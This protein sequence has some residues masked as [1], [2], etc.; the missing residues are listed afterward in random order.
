[1][2]AG[3]CGFPDAIAKSARA[4]YASW[5][6]TREA[7][8]NCDQPEESENKITPLCQASQCVD[9]YAIP[10]TRWTACKADDDCEVDLE[11][12]VPTAVNKT[13]RSDPGYLRWRWWRV[14]DAWDKCSDPEMARRKGRCTQGRCV[15]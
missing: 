5:A 7:Q 11:C 1:M 3:A 13:T 2:A 15:P 14:V 8:I 10:Q 9:P 6:K 12:D 4:A